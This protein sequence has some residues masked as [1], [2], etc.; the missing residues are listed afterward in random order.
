[1]P[2]TGG[3]TGKTLRVDLTTRTV[4]VEDTLTKYG[5]FWGG[6]G[7][8]YKV[9]WD[10]V[11]NTVE[12]YD[13]ENRIIFGWGPTAGTGAPCGGRTC[14]TALCP[15]HGDGTTP[16]IGAVATGHM[17]GHFCSEAKYAGWDGIIVKG[18]A[19]GPCYIAIRD[20]KVE[21]VDA[22]KLWGCGLYRVTAEITEAMGTTCQVAAIGIAGQNLV[23][24][25][26]VMTSSSHSA[27]AGMGAVLGSKNCV[28]I[29]VVGTGTVKIAAD[30]KA[31][32]ALIENAMA[33]VGSNNAAFLPNTPQPW[34]EYS[35][36]GQRWYAKKGQFWGAANPPVETGTCDPHDR[37]SVGYR[38]LKSDPGKIGE[39]Y[40]VRMEGCHA[41]PV[42][43]HQLINVP[44]AVKWDVSNTYAQ[45]TCTGWWGN[46]VMDST[47]YT[48]AMATRGDVAMTRLESYVVGKHM[49]DDNGLHNN[50]GPTTSIFNYL[51]HD[52]EALIK[53]VVLGNTLTIYGTSIDEW[54]YL[55]KGSAL[56]DPTKPGYSAT[57]T[58]PDSGLPGLFTL[59]EAGDLR[60]ITEWGRIVAN[61]IGKFG[62]A[63]GDPHELTLQTWAPGGVPIRAGYLASTESGD[64][65]GFGHAWHHADAHVG[66][67]GNIFND[68]THAQ[69]HSWGPNTYGNING[70]P[71]AM[72]GPLYEEQFIKGGYGPG[73]AACWD[74]ATPMNVYKARAARFAGN[75][76][77]LHDS[78]GLCNWMYPWLASPLKERGYRGDITLESQYWS[79][80]T[81]DTKTSYELDQEAERFV[82]LLRCLTIKRWAKTKGIGAVQ[83][84]TYHDS[85]GQIGYRTPA[86][87]A[88]YPNWNTAGGTLETFYTEMG[89]DV[90]TGAPTRARLTA[91]GMAD[92][93]DT[94]KALFPG[95]IW[96]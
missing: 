35:A 79:L 33:L 63:L 90:T 55:T 58:N 8:A 61:R 57:G 67:L 82:N 68:N 1:M 50:Y 28:G 96:G 6:T 19:S 24:Q 92:V 17:G 70:L 23:A 85:L 15:A 20:D 86:K 76:K 59:R 13:P 30:K 71:L 39:A 43:C 94:L 77:F 44:S 29:G 9:L 81:G 48:A 27:G 69:N 11:P 91:L 73:M 47:K 34:A 88:Y 5:K 65:W 56:G 38:C 60:G 16:V 66:M 87:Q 42:R 95:S 64:Y 75:R 62:K 36:S 84:R 74:Y 78:M 2:I 26:V 4:T 18:K 32:R 51:V 89:W 25:S 37:Q 14:I 41:C 80:L 46:G 53:P 49:T 54:N 40:T 3:F 45:N 22:P 52:A 83:I 7:M 31:W 72:R 12:P 10:E 93:A 21:I